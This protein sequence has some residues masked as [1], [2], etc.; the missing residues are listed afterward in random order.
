MVQRFWAPTVEISETGTLVSLDDYEAVRRQRDE[1]L[2]ML[3]RG[4]FVFGG[5]DVIPKR[6]ESDME[7]LIQRIAEDKEND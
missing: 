7:E 1:L 5:M 2:E 4:I 3:K 6:L